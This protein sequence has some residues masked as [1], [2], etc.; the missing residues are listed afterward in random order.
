MSQEL[1]E[2][3]SASAKD[4]A[5]SAAPGPYRVLVADDDA[6][7]R[8]GLI[9]SLTAIPEVQICGHATNARETVRMAKRTRPD[10]VILGMNLRAV[11]GIETLRRIRKALPRTEVLVVTLHDSPEVARIALRSGARGFLS[12]SDPP[13]AVIAAMREVRNRRLHVT[14]QIA[15]KLAGETECIAE[16]NASPDPTLT[17]QEIASVLARSEMKMQADLAQ[18]VEPQNRE[19]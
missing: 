8:L 11:S 3:R 15:L 18:M 6:A 12:K 17:Q 14:R 19:F 1:R 7:G 9:V 2:L 13:E 4:S 10:L 16:L 5:L